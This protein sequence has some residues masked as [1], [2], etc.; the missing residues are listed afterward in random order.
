MVHISKE[1]KQAIEEMPDKEKNK[2]LLRLI[3]KDWM[4]VQQ[5][6][7]K[8]L[9]GEAIKDEKKEVILNRIEYYNF[10][11][12]TPGW[13]MMDLRDFSGDVTR[14]YKITKDKQGE[15]ELLLKLLIDGMEK[16]KSMLRRE[17][18]RASKFAEYVVKKAWTILEKIDKVHEDFH[19][20]F[21]SDVNKLLGLL[22]EYEPTKIVAEAMAL[23]GEFE[24]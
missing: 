24:V 2:L 16:P 4:L 1:L 9:G 12:D 17:H 15:I 21:E 3:K 14:Y 6:E 8:L 7:F 19:I 22:Y 20:E 11:N 13:L 18:R 5:L 23:P 10:F